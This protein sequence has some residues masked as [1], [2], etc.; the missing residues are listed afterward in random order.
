MTDH[1]SRTRLP[2]S[3]WTFALVAALA[4]GLAWL[5]YASSRG[6]HNG[7]ESD[8][9]RRWVVCQYVRA[10]VNPY[11]LAL[12]ALHHTYG[13]LGG[14]RAK[15]RVYAV[16]RLAAG[17]SPP[18]GRTGNLLAAHGTPEAVYPPSADLLFALTIGALP[19]GNVHF[20]GVFANFGLLLLCALL[21][22]NLPAGAPASS[23]GA[24]VAA[25]GV[26]LLWSP[27]Q[28]A[29]QA[30]QFSVLV[31]VC[32]ILACRCLERNE[33]LAG[34]WLALALVKPSLALPFLILPLVRGRWRTLAVAAGLHL[35]ATAV[36]ALRFGRA[37]W[38]LVH[39]WTAV[40][41]YF[42]QG[43]FTLQEVLSALRLADTA[44]GLAVVGGF[45]L[46]ALAWCW[47]NRAAAD[48]TLVDFLCFVSV[49]WTYHG[50]YDFVI[51]LVPLA[52]RL[53]AP[54]AVPVAAFVPAVLLF[55][56]LSVA[57]SSAVYGN[58]LHAAARVVRHAARLLMAVGF[59]GIA[60][61]VWWSARHARPA[62]EPARSGAPA[63]GRYEVARLSA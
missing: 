17:D 60:L 23:A 59:A 44:A 15:P 63:D 5:G 52:R 33:Y 14:G 9:H 51:L 32:V 41:A 39:Q 7:R 49:L 1:G 29:V 47:W 16:P 25:L 20:A 21:L 26:L 13:E 30:G 42:T 12:T 4:A 35:A 18:D 19:E 10:G 48:A 50:P 55:V 58:E 3:V 37:P 40:A 36:Q 38:E 11:P 6:L 57:A 53:L 62:E 24:F 43:Q 28:S 54:A 27:T 56:C 31:T 61:E 45:A 34:A 22:S 46:F 8:L 2:R